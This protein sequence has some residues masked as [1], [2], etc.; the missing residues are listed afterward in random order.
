MRRAIRR[1]ALLFLALWPAWALAA[2]DIVIA[3]FEG[4]DYGE[5][6]VEGEAF[7]PGPAQ[8]TLPGQMPV[9]GYLGHGLVNSFFRG[10]GATGTLTGPPIKIERWYLNFLIGGGKYPGETCL[11]L[12]MDGQ[13]VRTATGPNDK[14]GGSERL[15]WQ[16]WDVGEFLGKSASLRIVDRRTGGWGHVNVDQ[17][18]QSDE[19]LQEVERTVE[20]TLQ[21]RYLNFP[22]KSGAEMRRM[23]VQFA[24]GTVRDFDIELG[25][26]QPDFWVFMDVSAFKGQ[27]ATIH[28]NLVAKKAGVLARITNDD[29]IK[30][31]ADL[32]HERY[33]PQFH[34]S[35][36]RGWNNDPNGLVYS[37]G[38]YHLFYQHNP[39]GWNWGN[40]HWG[41]AVSK[42]LVHWTEL[43]EA[44]YPDPLGPMFSGSA[45]VDVSN[46]AGFRTGNE[47]V[48]VCIYT[49]AGDPVTQCIAYSNDR[50]RTFT[51]YEGNPV[52]PHIIGANRDP[53]VIWYEPDRKWVM[54]LYLD[55]NDYALFTSPDL[56][57]WQRLC[58][59]N[60]PGTSE[61]PE[62][63]EIPVDG[64]KGDTRWIFYGGNGQYLIGRFDGKAFTSESGP[65]RLNFGNCFYASQTLS[66]LPPE[67]GRRIQIGWGTV[68]LPGMPF[69]QMMD[70]P[71]EL[72]LRTTEDGLQLFALPVREIEALHARKH[73]WKDL[74]LKEGENPLSGISGDLFDIRAEF[75]VGNAA[76]FGF[77]VRGIP[78]I[79]DAKSRQLNCPPCGAPLQP[80][81]G[82]I[83]LQLLVDRTSIESYGN[84][85]RL[86][87]PV[88][89]IPSDQIKSL[90]V[91]T[92]GGATRLTSLEVYELK[93]AWE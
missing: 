15:S 63:F 60:L 73:V 20:I 5:W 53:K 52:L 4:T 88:G 67:E 75:K 43:G 39:Y 34:F 77:Y 55:Q 61:C 51:K 87:M 27:Q 48:L 50:G 62:F 74:A 30:G 78:V 72:T 2:P 68:N 49:A 1:A 21:K 10:D 18:T 86:Y 69:N 89:V 83:R 29:E 79:Y 56:K 32:Y 57:Q 26:D 16:S 28:T 91:F 31:A 90:D 92:R 93:S 3:D 19:S 45:V 59:V 80:E 65:H 47:P 6:R 37:Q 84:N 35:S 58:D 9:S 81:N 17:I 11:D 46:T 82:K 25:L 22:V 40:M 14:P 76:Q 38:E 7:G 66:G 23:G 64:N 41:Q 33:R 24:D 70:F 85:G 71:V 54:A 42:D 44:L 36:R 13:V 12:L 8:G